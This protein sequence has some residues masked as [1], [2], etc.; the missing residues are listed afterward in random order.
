MGKTLYN[1]AL[2]VEHMAG[3]GKLKD[4]IRHYRLRQEAK[5]LK[6]GQ[7]NDNL[8]EIERVQIKDYGHLEEIEPGCYPLVFNGVASGW[9]ACR[10]WDFEY[11]KD[12]YGDDKSFILY[13]E[14]ENGEMLYEET[15]LRDAIDRMREDPNVNLRFQPLLQR[16]PQMVED[17]DIRFYDTLMPRNAVNAN[18]QF[19]MAGG[20]AFTPIHT[21]I[22]N[23]LFLQVFGEKEWIVYPPEDTMGLSPKIERTPYFFS[24]FNPIRDQDKGDNKALKGYRTVLGPGDV[25]YLPS[26]WWHFVRNLSDCISV[27]FRW[28]T[29]GSAAK[30]SFTLS[31]L[32]L[33]SVNPPIWTTIRDKAD[34]SKVV[35][36]RKKVVKMEKH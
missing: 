21:A 11:I 29:I 27:G 8:I 28:T 19:F 25:L 18:K 9:K 22:Q 1:A 31:M 20:G 23:L 24:D 26:F 30:G 17:L 33:M 3:F 16:H 13:S 34:F 14:T 36:K 5:Y 7:K 4:I 10:K 32:T 12:N 2:F 6:E 35:L 15:T